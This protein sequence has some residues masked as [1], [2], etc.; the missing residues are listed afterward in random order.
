MIIA[1]YMTPDNNWIGACR[2]AKENGYQTTTLRQRCYKSPN[3]IA[4]IY[5]GDL[6]KIHAD[7]AQLG[8]PE[9]TL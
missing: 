4:D 2:W 9:L 1:I 8:I 3:T 7:Y 5:Y 6:E